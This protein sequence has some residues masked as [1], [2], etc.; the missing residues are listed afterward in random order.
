MNQTQPPV[1]R[2]DPC[3]KQIVSHSPHAAML[4]LLN[5][6]QNRLTKMVQVHHD[7]SGSNDSYDRLTKIVEVKQPF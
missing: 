6:S 7:T 4:S 1:R 3:H 2:C 5:A